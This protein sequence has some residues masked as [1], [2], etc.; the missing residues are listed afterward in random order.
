MVV[1]PMQSTGGD[2]YIVY[3]PPQSS[4]ARF[5]V[6]PISESMAIE[7]RG[8]RIHGG[9]FGG[10]GS[11]TFESQAL[12]HLVIRIFALYVC[13]NTSGAPFSH[14]ERLLK[15]SGRSLTTPYFICTNSWFWPVE[16][17]VSSAVLTYLK[18]LMYS[19]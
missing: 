18:K 8:P 13:G 5:S 17:P 2:N 4:Y 12:P 19:Y 7:T 9:N 10:L 14:W 3:V 16:R 15:V 1:P 6:S 11:V